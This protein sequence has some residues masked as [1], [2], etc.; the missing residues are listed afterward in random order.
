MGKTGYI[1]KE[2]GLGQLWTRILNNRRERKVNGRRKWQS[3]KLRPKMGLINREMASRRRGP[4]LGGPFGLEVFWQNLLDHLKH[5]KC[6]N[7]F[8]ELWIVTEKHYTITSIY[9]CNWSSSIVIKLN[10]LKLNSLILFYLWISQKNW[11]RNFSPVGIKLCFPCA[12]NVAGN[13]II[14]FFCIKDG[15]P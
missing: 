11:F 9:I 1:S 6:L 4:L 13:K 12:N 14:Y 7:R 5:N 2:T 3:D 15:N 8:L 10:Y